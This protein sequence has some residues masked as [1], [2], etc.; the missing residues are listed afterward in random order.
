MTK[1]SKILTLA[2][3]GLTAI[4]MLGFVACNGEEET[5]AQTNEILIGG[6]ESYDELTQMSWINSFGAVELTTEHKTQGDHA[7]KLTVRGLHTNSSKPQMIIPTDTDFVEKTDYTDV[8]SVLV[9]VY[10]DSDT[11]QKIGFQY[12]T[13]ADEK[14]VLSAEIFQTIP[15]KTTKTL[16]YKIDRDITAQFLNLDLV[17]SLR[18]TFENQKTYH[19]PNRVFYVDNMRV[20]TTDAPI[21]T[22]VPVRAEGEYESCDR[23][24]YLSV[25]ANILPKVYSD[26]T[27][28]FNDD[29]AYIKSGNGSFK[30]TSNYSG[31]SA[32]AN[33]SVGF[34]LVKSDYTDL[35]DYYSL[36]FWVYNDNEVDTNFHINNMFVPQNPLKAKEWTQIEL[37]VD[38]LKTQGLDVN[39]FL[40]MFIF[41]AH[42]DKPYTWYVD[43]IRLNKVAIDL[44]APVLNVTDDTANQK[45]KVEWENKGA[46]S[47]AYEVVVD[48]ETVTPSQDIGLTTTLEIPYGDYALEKHE[49]KVLVTANGNGEEKQTTEYRKVFFGFDS[50]PKNFAVSH[51]EIVT[52]TMPTASKG[53]ITW[54][55]EATKAISTGMEKDK[56]IAVETEGNTFTFPSDTDAIVRITWT[57]TVDGYSTDAYTYVFAQTAMFPLTDI[58]DDLY[59]TATYTGDVAKSDVE[60]I[61]GQKRLV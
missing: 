46:A 53:E 29:S 42:L 20:K 31:G 52:L 37:T 1:K 33:H 13:T 58:Y 56:V 9:D 8:E 43:D 30:L 34:K 19:E 23:P 51:G 36:S 25:W 41:H 50:V 60:I 17:T 55:A 22:S 45:L 4:G 54:K 12:L 35:S 11:D 18:L 47:Y 48:G 61:D 39:S 26:S 40:P 5:G 24:E 57:L 28:S 7:A 27:L 38:W 21:D 44:P 15:A 6:F 32:T 49:L 3:A 10:N 14:R 2:L 59:E 16:E